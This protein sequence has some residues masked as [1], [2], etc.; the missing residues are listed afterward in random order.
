MCVCVLLPKC[1]VCMRPPTG[2]CE[3]CVLC[4]HDGFLSPSLSPYLSLRGYDSR[5]ASPDLVAQD[6]RLQEMGQDGSYA[7]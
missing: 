3:I 4:G 1:A 6:D 2:L 7:R 5:V